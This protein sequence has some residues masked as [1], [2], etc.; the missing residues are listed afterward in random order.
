[1]NLLDMFLFLFRLVVHIIASFSFFLPCFSPFIWCARFFFLRVFAKHFSVMHF[2]SKWLKLTIAQTFANNILKYHTC[3]TPVN[4]IR[5]ILCYSFHRFDRF[6]ACDDKVSLLKSSN[7]F[8]NRL[9]WW[10]NE[11]VWEEKRRKK[12]VELKQTACLRM[13]LLQLLKP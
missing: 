10:V 1:M 3:L 9:E 12:D 13:L 4:R 11:R 2:M 5:K 7:S 6:Y 8:T